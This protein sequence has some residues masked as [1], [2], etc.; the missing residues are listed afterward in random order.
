MCLTG[1]VF[2][3]DMGMVPYLVLPDLISLDLA[4]SEV[5][6]TTLKRLANRCSDKVSIMTITF[7]PC[8]A[9]PKND[10]HVF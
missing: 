3:K 8:P 4:E 7:I 5:T 2:I 6:D 1:V 10:L 9:E